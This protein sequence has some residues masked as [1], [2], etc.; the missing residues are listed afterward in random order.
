MRARRTSYG[1]V[2]AALGAWYEL[3]DGFNGLELSENAILLG[4]AVVIGLAG[5]FG[6]V[7]FYKLIDLAHTAF[8]EWPESVLPSLGRLAYRP[9]TTGVGAVLAWWTM[10]RFVQGKD[11]LTVPDVQLAVVRRQGEIPAGPALMRPAASAITIGS[12]GSAGSEG[13]VAVFGA[14]VASRLGRAFRFSGSR[15]DNRLRVVTVFLSSPARAAEIVYPL[16]QRPLP[17]S[18]FGTVDIAD[19]AA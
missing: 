3:V 19:G 1:P 12:G 13:P 14:M 16:R 2:D 15:R 9:L 17:D 10:R 5:S 6:V 7:G 4:F 8:F 18:D 11:G